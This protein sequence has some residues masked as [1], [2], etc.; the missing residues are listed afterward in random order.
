VK[1]KPI[2]A[3][4]AFVLLGGAAVYV[5]RQPQ[6]GEQRDDQGGG[7]GRAAVAAPRVAAF[8]SLTVEAKGSRTM[9]RR[10]GE[11]FRVSAPVDYPADA[12]A[13]KAAFESL[14]RLEL[15][16]VVTDRV[17][18]Y[19]ELGVDDAAGVRI[20]A[21]GAGGQKVI[22]LM[23][24]KKVGDGTMVR[25]LGGAGAV[26]WQTPRSDL[27]EIYDKSTVEWRD[28]AITAFKAPDADRVEVAA[29]DGARIA[30]K[31]VA[32]SADRRDETWEVISSTVPIGKLDASV[33]H[34][35][36]TAMSALNAR[37]FADGVT[38]AAAGLD[39]PALTVT[40]SAGGGEP[41]K[42]KGGVL[43]IGKTSGNGDTF[44]KNRES[45]QIF[46]VARH[47]AERLARRPIQFRQKALCNISDADVIEVAITNGPDSYAITK[48]A[49]GWRAT[50]PAGLKVDQEKVV[51]F[52]TIFRAWSAPQIAE[53]LPVST[54][55]A[56]RA[57][58]VGRSKKGSCTIQVGGDAPGRPDS[59]LLRTPTARDLYV[60]PKWMVDRVVVKLDQIRVN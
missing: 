40:V 59:Y 39:P 48:D 5:T 53:G 50:R 45:P 28:R 18:R 9:I 33:P 57:L 30:V 6:K 29:A 14:Q 47:D 38:A 26:V 34:E 49:G 37:D 16:S 2:V 56:A 35:I 13:A 15:S 21:H 41:G 19:A 42:K 52:H 27:R 51:A 46:L 31:R 32:V 8:E 11:T 54:F 10:Q 60:V 22:E 24:G 7:E 12:G 55:G 23:I 43:F 36:I 1:R 44:V 58:I 4:S 17:Q 25:V 20:T 3:V